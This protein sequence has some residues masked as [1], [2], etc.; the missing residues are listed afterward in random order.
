MAKLE[1][2]PRPLVGVVTNNQVIDGGYQIT[3]NGIYELE[4]IA[5]ISGATPIML[6]A[7]RGVISA[8]DALG[9]CDGFYF[10]GG[11]ANIHPD[12]YGQALT[13]K[14]GDMNPC[15]DRLSIPL[16]QLAVAAGKPIFAVC[17]G[18]QELAVAFGST[19]HAEIGDLPGKMNHR[20]PPD[21]S[22][23]EK[24]EERQNITTT[25]GGQLAEILGGDK[26]LVNTLHGQAVDRPGERVTVEALADD[27]TIEAISIKDAP[28]FAIG[29]QWHPEYRAEEREVSK[30]LFAAFGQ[31]LHRQALARSASRAVT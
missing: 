31:A 30:L 15:R 27:G 14:H 16:I 8:E 20:M 26:F 12:H 28:S 1:R 6:P 19:L 10:P 2:K 5:Q 23:E 9:L 4:A 21:G 3:G 18:H 25:P 7:V 17:R 24:F 11:R 29:V 22:L 13:E